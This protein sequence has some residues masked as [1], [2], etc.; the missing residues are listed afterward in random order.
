MM[1]NAVLITR[2]VILQEPICLLWVSGLILAW[3]QRHENG[4]LA[5]TV[6]VSMLLFLVNALGGVYFEMWTPVL[7]QDRTGQWQGWLFGLL[8]FN[9]PMQLVLQTVA[10]SLLLFSVFNWRTTHWQ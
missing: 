6:G 10:W 2:N 1:T 7:L 8:T 5:L 9:Q 3:I 4:K